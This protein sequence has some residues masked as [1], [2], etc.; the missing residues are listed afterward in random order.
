MTLTKASTVGFKAAA[1]A[2]TRRL[3]GAWRFRWWGT[4]THSATHG[5]KVDDGV[6]QKYSSHAL[7]FLRQENQ[8]QDWNLLVDRVLG[9]P[10][11]VLSCLEKLI[12]IVVPNKPHMWV[13]VTLEWE[14]VE[15][16]IGPHAVNVGSVD[17]RDGV[18][19]QPESSNE[20]IRVGVSIPELAETPGGSVKKNAGRR[21]WRRK[22][23]LWHC[24]FVVTD[25]PA[26]DAEV[27]DKAIPPIG[28]PTCFGGNCRV[29]FFQVNCRR[30]C[31]TILQ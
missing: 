24:H 25:V 17:V 13:G 31:H 7:H 27:D 3:K 26:W 14:I 10:P 23:C 9:K 5:S 30:G 21:V 6:G 11:V 8:A 12:A 16:P 20:D 22:G 19:S 4:G 2:T 29:V 1:A 18:N 15:V 28:A